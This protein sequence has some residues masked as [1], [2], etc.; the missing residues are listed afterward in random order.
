MNGYKSGS[1]SLPEPPPHILEE[2]NSRG[3]VIELRG[4]KG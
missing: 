3:F 1:R 4:G 2:I